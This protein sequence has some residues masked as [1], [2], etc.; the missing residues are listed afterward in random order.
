[1]IN[2]EISERE[3]KAIT[4]E[5]G[6]IAVKFARFVAD[7]K[8]PPRF[9]DL[10]HGYGVLHEE[11]K[12]TMF[13]IESIEMIEGTIDNLVIANDTENLKLQL[14][15]M[16]RKSLRAMEELAQLAAVSDKFIDS[17]KAGENDGIHAKK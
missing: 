6:D 5:L 17:I 8:H 11:V 1:M 14:A 13:E 3:Q 12:E 7:Q 15:E 10:N 16:K 9:T 4:E 2:R